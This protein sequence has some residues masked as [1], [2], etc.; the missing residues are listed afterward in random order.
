MAT[1]ADA[2]PSLAALQ[3]GHADRLRL[4]AA[5]CYLRAAAAASPAEHA[6]WLWLG[7]MAEAEALG[8]VPLG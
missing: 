2:T 1:P 7:V 5:D 8:I 3:A 6:H 4:F